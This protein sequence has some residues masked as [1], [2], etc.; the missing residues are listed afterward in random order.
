MTQRPPVT[1]SHLWPLIKAQIADDATIQDLL[2]GTGHVYTEAEDYSLP[3]GNEGEPWIRIV[4]APAASLWSFF[5]TPGLLTPCAFIVRAECTKFDGPGY[6][7]QLALEAV[8][9]RVQV[10]LDQFVPEPVVGIS[11]RV[12]F[13]IYHHR[14]LEPRILWDEGRRLYF[15]T[16]EYRMELTSS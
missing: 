15:L 3:E 11:T 1:T 9:A 8:L 2:Y 6:D 10:L 12:A 16:S 5:D 13:P 14:V 4:I 7:H